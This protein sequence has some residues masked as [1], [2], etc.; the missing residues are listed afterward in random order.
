[1][2]PNSASTS[3]FKVMELHTNTADAILGHGICPSFN[4]QLNMVVLCYNTVPH[5]C[6]LKVE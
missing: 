4:S 5:S 2:Y 1:M 3:K 6:W